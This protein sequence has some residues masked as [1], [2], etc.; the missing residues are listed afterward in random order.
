MS[1]KD[2]D[3]AFRLSKNGVIKSIHDKETEASIKRGHPAPAYSKQDLRDWLTDD[4]LFNL[5]YN[6]W[7]NCGYVK[8][9]KPSLDRLDDYK[10]YTFD[11][12]QLGTWWENNLNG[13]IAMKNG[14]NNKQS[15]EVSRCDMDGNIIETYYSIQE[16]SR[17]TG[18]PQGNISACLKGYRI[19]KGKAKQALSAGGYKWR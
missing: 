6:N 12:I 10:P 5:L 17:Q 19:T 1:K 2:T 9:L 11:N 16:A 8:D 3:L 7:V 13:N 14:T 4:W 18:I 15:R